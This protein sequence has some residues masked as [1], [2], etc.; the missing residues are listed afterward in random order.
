MS[1]FEGYGVGEN[2]LVHGIK[3]CEKDSA[4]HNYFFLIIVG[5]QNRY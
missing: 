1:E 3:I 4:D 2:A 5:S